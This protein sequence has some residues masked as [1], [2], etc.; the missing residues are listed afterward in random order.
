MISITSETK[1]EMFVP[2]KHFTF[3]LTYPPMIDSHIEIFTLKLL[4]NK[5]EDFIHFSMTYLLHTSE[6]FQHILFYPSRQFNAKVSVKMISESHV[7]HKSLHTSCEMRYLPQ[8]IAVRN[9]HTPSPFPHLHQQHSNTSL[10]WKTF[11][12]FIKLVSFPNK[13]KANPL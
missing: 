13:H 5:F 6:A 10:H 2:F 11:Q 4:C 7:S 12:H 9:S 3:S 1:M 8:S